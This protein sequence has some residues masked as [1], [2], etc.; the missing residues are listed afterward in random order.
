[1]DLALDY[2]EEL[3]EQAFELVHKNPTNPRQA[4]LRR[5]VSGAYYALFHLLISETIV[6][7]RLD[8]SRPGLARMFEHRVMA[9]ASDRILD[10]KA[11]PFHGEDGEVV[12]KLRA[13][14][15][16]FGQLQTKR[17][18]ADYDNAMEWTHT[19]AL[20]E[21]VRAAEMFA[22]WQTIRQEKIAQDFLV[23]LIIRPRS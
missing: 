18:Q 11:F 7:W 16:A 23:S 21:V 19:E 3:L 8:S 1:M 17:H 10:A 13:L 9:K 15:E 14:A 20:R 22:I 5:S 12:R 6:H 2:H 4:D